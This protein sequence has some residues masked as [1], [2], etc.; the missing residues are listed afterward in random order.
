MQLKIFCPC[1]D[2][3]IRDTSKRDSPNTNK[4]AQW[5]KYFRSKELP[6]GIIRSFMVNLSCVL[7][8]N[9]CLII[10]YY[11]DTCFSPEPILNKKKPLLKKYFA[12]KRHTERNH[13]KESIECS[14]NRQ[15]DIFDLFKSAI[16]MNKLNYAT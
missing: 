3:L 8:G 16:V 12:L 13:F 2:I 11:I 4:L 7:I 15:S 14:I 10:K 9:K 6:K 5:L 1:F